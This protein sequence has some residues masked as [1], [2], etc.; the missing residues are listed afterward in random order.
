MKKQ[1]QKS[2]NDNSAQCW[3]F[4]KNVEFRLIS[5]LLLTGTQIERAELAMMIQTNQEGIKV[6]VVGV[7]KRSGGYCTRSHY[8]S[9]LINN[10]FDINNNK[11]TIQY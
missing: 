10:L 7:G 8:L 5:L 1:S 2:R 11:F 3:D 6:R 4:L 9:Q